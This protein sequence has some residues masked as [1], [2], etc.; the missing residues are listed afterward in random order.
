M[1]RE[2][3]VVEGFHDISAVR[4]AVQAELIATNGFALGPDTLTTIRRAHATCGVIVLTDPDPAGEQIRRRVE[5]AVGPCKHAWISREDCLRGSDIGVENAPPEA[6]RDAL[7]R[8][9]ATVGDVRREFG[10]G[11]LW[12]HGL[13]GVPDARDRRVRLGAALGL[14]YGNA[15]QLLKRL[16]H[17]GVTRDELEDAASRL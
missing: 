17:L 8:A 3:I 5:D 11:D 15:R 6:I 14:G 1:I 13:L 4:Q 2:L 12:R 16:N 9:R 10:V 7:A